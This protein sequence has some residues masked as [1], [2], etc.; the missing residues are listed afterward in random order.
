[1]PPK[2]AALNA[3]VWGQDSMGHHCRRYILC[4]YRLR[5][6]RDCAELYTSTARLEV[7]EELQ[8][9]IER[10]EELG[11]T[12]RYATCSVIQNTTSDSR[13]EA[14]PVGGVLYLV[15]FRESEAPEESSPPPGGRVSRNPQGQ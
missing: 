15:G 11:V 8:T 3:P 2:L 7:F 12:L 9:M 5:D 10:L 13:Q 4:R 14:L 6:Y 1:M